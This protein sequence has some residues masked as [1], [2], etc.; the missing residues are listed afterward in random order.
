MLGRPASLLF[1][2]RWRRSEDGTRIWKP[3]VSKISQVHLAPTDPCC[4]NKF[5][6]GQA[7]KYDRKQAQIPPCE[8][9]GC[10]PIPGRGWWGRWHCVRYSQPA[11]GLAYTALNFVSFKIPRD[12]RLHVRLIALNGR[13]TFTIWRGLC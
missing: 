4:V 3:L 1:P 8:G 11:G 9:G 10:T 6:C 5:G 7:A 13:F 2:D 12:N